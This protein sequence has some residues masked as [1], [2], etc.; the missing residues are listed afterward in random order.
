MSF[1]AKQLFAFAIG[2]AIL[3]ASFKVVFPHAIGIIPPHI[4]L[5]PLPTSP[6]MNAITGAISPRTPSPF[7][8]QFP[9]QKCTLTFNGQGST[10][11]TKESNVRIDFQTPRLHITNVLVKNNKIYLWNAVSLQGNV[12][13]MSTVSSNFLLAGYMNNVIAEYNKQ[14]NNCQ[15]IPLSDTIFSVPPQVT[16]VTKNGY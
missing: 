4:I 14:K 9:P 12:M 5:T 6:Y 1:R 3:F 11:Y 2:I 15:Q 8:L 13:D 10:V 7:P 16:F